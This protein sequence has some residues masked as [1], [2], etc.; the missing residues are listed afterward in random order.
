LGT[1]IQHTANE[2]ATTIVSLEAEA[3]RGLQIV[4]V[5]LAVIDSPATS[6]AREEWMKIVTTTAAMTISSN[7][8]SSL[9]LEFWIAMLQLSAALLAKAAG[10]M[11][12]RYITSYA[13]L[14]GL[15]NQL[16]AQTSQIGDEVEAAELHGLLEDI[17]LD[18]ENLQ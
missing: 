13:A 14:M 1:I 17:A 3:N 11:M 10:G 7:S 9:T 12:K 5:L 6:V 2:N 4:R 18:L 8:P 16:K 15:V